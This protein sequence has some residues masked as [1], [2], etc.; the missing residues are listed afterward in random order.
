MLVCVGRLVGCSARRAAVVGSCLAQLP[1]GNQA[2]A[3]ASFGSARGRCFRSMWTCPAQR[4]SPR[5]APRRRP[6]PRSPI[7]LHHPRSAPPL[8]NGF[9]ASPHH[10]PG[11]SRLE[12][13]LPIWVGQAAVPAAAGARLAVPIDRLATTPSSAY[14]PARVP[15]RGGGGLIRPDV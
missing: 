4:R 2:C 10:P 12:R 6:A 14:D 1:H 7:I 5:R 13:Q 11:S 9:T 3:W 15:R 8:R